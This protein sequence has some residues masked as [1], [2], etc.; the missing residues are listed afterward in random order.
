ML[1]LW[2]ELRFVHLGY[3]HLMWL[4]LAVAGLLVWLELR[5]RDLTGRFV[6]AIMQRRLARQPS[7]EQR[8]LRVGFLFGCLAFGILALM[9]PQTPGTTQSLRTGQVAADIMV[10]LDVS[11][12]MLADDAAP[13]RL[14]RAKAEVAELAS[15]LDGHRI[16]LVAFA[17]RAAVLSPLTSDE[18]FFRMILDGADTRSVSRGGTEIG[19][20]IRKAVQSFEGDVGAKLILLITDGEDHG[21]YAEE[22]AQE[23]LEAGVRIVTIGFGSEDGSQITLVDPDTGARRVLTDR[24]GA[25]VTSRLDGELLRKIALTTQGAYVPAG[26]SAL[27]LESIVADHI[28][29]IVRA[30]DDRPVVRHLPNEYYP[31]LVLLALVCLLAALLVASFPARREI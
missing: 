4:A 31:V 25:P 17:G 5:G 21:G 8:V 7:T 2:S 19:A 29:P 30:A 13:T 28:T 12:S 9:R 1:T 22:A 6:S 11:K 23:A 16:G 15:S 3:V 26:V 20:A 27:D 18:G 10:V 14:D 24:D